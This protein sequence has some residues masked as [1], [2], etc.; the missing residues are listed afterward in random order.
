MNTVNFLNVTIIIDG[1]VEVSQY[2][3]GDV[4]LECEGRSYMLDIVESNSQ[5][6]NGQTVIE[7]KVAVDT[8]TFDETHTKYDLLPED[9]FNKDFKASIYIGGEY[10]EEPETQ[11]LFVK[12]DGGLTKAVNLTLE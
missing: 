9:F 4:T 12:F 6:I 1:E 3:L 8:E 11:T 2:D 10:E 5:F 7:C